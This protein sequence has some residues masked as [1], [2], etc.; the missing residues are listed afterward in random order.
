MAYL[1][2]FAEEH[3]GTVKRFEEFYRIDQARAC[4]K[5]LFEV[6]SHHKKAN[7]YQPTTYGKKDY[8]HFYVQHEDGSEEKRAYYITR[9]YKT[10]KFSVRTNL[11]MKER[12]IELGLKCEY[13]G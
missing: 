10:E 8:F 12:A 1:V 2:N 13:F 7:E 9:A 3:T 11:D 5:E 4:M 6:L